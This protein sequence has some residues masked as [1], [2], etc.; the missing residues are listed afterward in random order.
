LTKLVLSQ[1]NPDNQIS[2]RGISME[3]PDADVHQFP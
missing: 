2:H 3:M 1:I